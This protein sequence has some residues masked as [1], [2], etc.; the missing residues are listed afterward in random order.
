MSVD[1]L[2]KT[3]IKQ[4]HEK[5]VKMLNLIDIFEKLIK[6]HELK[7]TKNQTKIQNDQ[8]KSVIYVD[9]KMKIRNAIWKWF[10]VNFIWNQNLKQCDEKRINFLLLFY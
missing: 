7:Q 6:K 8:I 1:D 9:E 5:F 10:A 4:K 3:L 2:I